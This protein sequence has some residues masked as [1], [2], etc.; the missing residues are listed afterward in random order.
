MWA[1]FCNIYSPVAET[2]SF[3]T[4]NVYKIEFENWYDTLKYS[5]NIL[6]EDCTHCTC[7]LK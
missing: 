1:P 6:L 7:C 2:N 5:D 4:E 3:E